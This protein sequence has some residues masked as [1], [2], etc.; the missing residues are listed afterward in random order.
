MVEN[1]NLDAVDSPDHIHG[2]FGVTAAAK[3]LALL[4]EQEGLRE[5]EGEDGLEVLGV[6]MY[7]FRGERMVVLSRRVQQVRQK[8]RC[9]MREEYDFQGGF[10]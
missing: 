5:A 7:A 1:I 6:G 9:I 4:D 2:Q 10:F 3:N 8:W